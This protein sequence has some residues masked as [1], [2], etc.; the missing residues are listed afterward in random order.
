MI[1]LKTKTSELK[2]KAIVFDKDG[3]LTEGLEVWRKIFSKQME[4]ASS[5]GLKIENEAR[6]IF[7]VDVEN[8]ST[9]L[10][11]AY[12][13]E[14][15]TLLAASIWLS[16]EFPWDECRRLSKE[17]VETAVKKMSDDEIFTPT[18]GAKEALDFISQRVPVA[19]ATSDSKS[20]V[21]RLLKKWKMRERVNLVITSQDVNAG[22]PAPDMLYEIC[23]A[24]GIECED[25][26]MIGDN[27]V[28]L[29][30]ARNAGAKSIIVGQESL[31]AD[32][33][34]ENLGELIP[35]D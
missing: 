2:A 10:A 4:I 24:F 23:N 26:V 22:K 25:I 9:P 17:I 31:G 20:N 18:K 13:S 8:Q 34:V 14:E 30:M 11:I 12:A 33:W 15:T 32:G 19:I 29:K 27:E 7:G 5:M 16:H 35:I 21:E 1:T 6:R 3:T 28:D